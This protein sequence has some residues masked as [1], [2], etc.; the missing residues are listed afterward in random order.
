MLRGKDAF[1]PE[2]CLFD[3]ARP[4]LTLFNQDPDVLYYGVMFVQF[5][6][7]F[8]LFAC[9]N[10]IIGGTL[11]GAGE[12]M[13]AMI[14]MLSTFVV[15]RQ[16]Y[17]FFISRATDSPLLIGLGYPLGWILC[18]ISL[19]FCYR[20]IPWEQKQAQRQMGTAKSA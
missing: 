19:L 3:F 18:C 20:L 10:D 12:A 17:L 5:I 6:S 16:I 2:T 9:V 13:A 15:S 4:L 1:S 14:C 8:Y 11:R 7:P